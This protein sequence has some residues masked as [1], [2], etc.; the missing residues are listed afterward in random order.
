MSVRVRL[1]APLFSQGYV[2]PTKKSDEFTVTYRDRVARLHR[3]PGTANWS[4][5]IRHEDGVWRSL[6]AG[7]ADLDAAR[8]AARDHLTEQAFRQKNG[9]VADAR[10]FKTVAES[11]IKE[12]ELQSSMGRTKTAQTYIDA[13]RRYH[14]PFLGAHNID[15]IDRKLLVELDEWRIAEFGRTPKRSTLQNHNAALNHVFTHAMNHGWLKQSQV[16]SLWNDGDE[17]ESRATFSQI[18][19]DRLR[20]YLDEWVTG[21]RNG[22]SSQVRFVLRD[23]ILFVAATGV[24]PGTETQSITWKRIEDHRDDRDGEVYLRVLVD[25]KTGPRWVIA[26]ESARDSFERL[27]QW[28]VNHRPDWP[29][30]AVLDGRYPHQSLMERMVAVLD[31]LGM[32]EDQL[33]QRRTLYSLR[34]YY[35]TQQRMK[36]IPYEVLKNQMGTSIAMLEKHYDHVTALDEA[37]RLVG[38]TRSSNAA[39]A[40]DL[41]AALD[42]RKLFVLEGGKL[43][44]AS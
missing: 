36:G 41:G 13:L 4:F 28:N 5:K 29:V 24:R 40:L 26:P 9:L 10:K 34:H 25:G 30:F 38:R 42:Q 15:R 8:D 14:I 19:F 33:G 17:G 31:D 43:Q 22:L 21:G 7:T 32:R 39:L 44:L 3:R 18:E 12:L 6:T 16:P 2:V 27:R 37:A 35:A 11:C 20:R 23:L 1:W